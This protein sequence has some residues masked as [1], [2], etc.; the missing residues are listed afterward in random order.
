MNLQFF[1]W[2][3]KS[4]HY[5]TIFPFLVRVSA[6]GNPLEKT[7]VLCIFKAIV[8]YF[9]SCSGNFHPLHLRLPAK[10]VYSFFKSWFL[11]RQRAVVLFRRR[12]HCLKPKSFWSSFFKILRN[13]SC[14]FSLFPRILSAA[15]GFL[16][17]KWNS[18]HPKVSSLLC[19]FTF[20]LVVIL[21]VWNKIGVPSD[22][23]LFW[24]R[25]KRLV[26]RN[27][28]FQLCQLQCEINYFFYNHTLEKFAMNRV[29]IQNRRLETSILC[30]LPLLNR[31]LPNLR[32]RS[33]TEFP[34]L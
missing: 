2:V 12:R 7:I 13:L 9:F 1:I 17:Y 5:W 26:W 29:W 14:L 11:S 23:L 18:Y 33:Y 22:R 27:K 8:H 6:R 34:S 19:L 16:V 21:S 32:N 25:R 10:E 30:F 28:S 4:L 15:V 31:N 20:I 3:S 24:I